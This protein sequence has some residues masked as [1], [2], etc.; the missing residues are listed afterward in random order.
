MSNAETDQERP[1]IDVELT[2]AIKRTPVVLVLDTSLSM[3]NNDRIGILNETLHEFIEG[4]K[5]NDELADALLLCII[6]FGGEAT[7]TVPWSAIDAVSFPPLVADGAT[8]MGDAVL[9]A[10]GETDAL[11]AELK[12][13][14]TPYNIPWFILMSDGEPTDHWEDA[15]ALMQ[16]RIAAVKIVSF[17]F[18]IPPSK[19]EILKRFVPN[20]RPVYSVRETD[21][22]RL[23]VEWLTG[24]LVKVAESSPGQGAK[25]DVPT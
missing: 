20:G 16:E 8:P 4:I 15:A 24:S 13:T 10:I 19:D 2:N 5:T 7:V 22:R 1:A 6:T 17:A 18:G 11:R 12:R 23:F 14:G 21:I 9:L 3:K 25:I